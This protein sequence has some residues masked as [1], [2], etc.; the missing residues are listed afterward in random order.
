MTEVQVDRTLARH[1]FMRTLDTMASRY[2]MLPSR[3]LVEASTLDL[4]ILHVATEWPDDAEP[5]KPR[6]PSQD[7][8]LAMMEAVR[9]R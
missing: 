6:Q 3:V 7:E 5:E 4:E 8:L 2:G 9:R 1:Q